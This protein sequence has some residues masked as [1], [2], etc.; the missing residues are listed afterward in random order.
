[1]KKFLSL[2]LIVIMTLSLVACG[3]ENDSTENVSDEN[4]TEDYNYPTKDNSSEKVTVDYNNERDFEALLNADIDVTGKVVTFTVDKIAPD[5]AFGFNLQTGEHLNFCSEEAQDVKVGDSV[6]VR[7]TAVETFLYSYIISYERIDDSAVVTKPTKEIKPY[8]SNTGVAS[9]TLNEPESYTYS[10][11]EIGYGSFDFRGVFEY[12]SDDEAFNIS[13]GSFNL[14]SSNTDVVEL[15]PYPLQDKLT[16]F[17]VYF[18]IY[19]NNAGTAKIH[20][21][22]KDGVVVS[23]E[24]TITVTEDVEDTDINY[25]IIDKSTDELDRVTIKATISPYS[26]DEAGPHDITVL[27][28][29]IVKYEKKESNPLGVCVLL[30]ATGDDTDGPYTISICE[31]APDGDWDSV[32]TKGNRDYTGYEYKI[33]TRTYSEREE[34]RKG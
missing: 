13:A 15:S 30:Y 3:A 7:V 28:K 29:T 24:I 4:V 16:K 9:I 20:I 5:S 8:V 17:T 26:E 27:L 32:A 1:M 34:I 2:M 10:V 22:T 12:L 25:F 14:V 33:L 31:Y 23:D 19:A 21:E 11:G 6:T 18:F